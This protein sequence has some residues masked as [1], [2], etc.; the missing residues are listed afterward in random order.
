MAVRVPFR[1]AG[2]AQPLILVPAR[3]NGVGPFPFILD[4][5]AGVCLL[6]PELARWADVAVAARETAL[7]AAGPLGVG[8]GTAGRLS[9]G[10]VEVP[11]VPV[12][13]TEELDRIGEAVGPGSSAIWATA[14]SSTSR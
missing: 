10:E 13:I 2:G 1:L 8:L 11:D 3:A 9:V 6:S 12:A 4:T 5:G 7:G 14:F